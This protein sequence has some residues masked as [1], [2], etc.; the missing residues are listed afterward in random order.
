MKLSSNRLFLLVM[1]L[2][3]GVM[4][5]AAIGWPLKT[6]YTIG[7]GFLPVVM[8]CLIIACCVILFFFDKSTPDFSLNKHQLIRLGLYF[9]G[10]IAMI[11]LME[12]F[13]IIASVALFIFY[14]VFWVEKNPLLDSLKVAL[15]ATL[16]VWAIF[17][18]WLDIPITI[19]NFL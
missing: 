10:L 3:S 17:D 1:A 13:G 8:L 19:F 18:L 16:V 14:I 12:H 15:T 4:L 11:L 5:S 9:V 2:L 6:Q 7:P